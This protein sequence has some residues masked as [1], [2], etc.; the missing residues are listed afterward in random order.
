MKKRKTTIVTAPVILDR[1]PFCQP[2]TYPTDIKDIDRVC[3]LTPWGAASVDGRIGERH[4]DVLHCLDS[5]GVVISK[6]LDPVN[7][8]CITID[9][10]A[11]TK[12]VEMETHQARRLLHDLASARVD[13]YIKNGDRHVVGAILTFEDAP[14]TIENPWA[15]RRDDAKENR[16]LWTVTLSEHWTALLAWSKTHGWYQYDLSELLDMTGPTRALARW[17]LGHKQVNQP[18]DSIITYFHPSRRA[19]KLKAAIREDADLLEAVGIQLS[20]KGHVTKPMSRNAP[21]AARNAPG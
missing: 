8:L 4:K 6:S 12:K 20:E 2:T 19:D 16:R 14:I 11:L 1:I 5:E 9:P 13:L 21:G 18:L 7:R 10:Y 17:A 3:W 15:G